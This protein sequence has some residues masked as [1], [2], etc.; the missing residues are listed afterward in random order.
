MNDRAL[1]T[2][3]GSDAR[4]SVCTPR[5]GSR[6]DAAELTCLARI[7]VGGV[8]RDLLMPD[9]D[10]ANALVDAP[11]VDVDDVSA[12]ERKDG[13]DALVLQRPGD[14]VPAG[15]DVGVTALSLQRVLRGRG[16]PVVGSV[17]RRLEHRCL[18]S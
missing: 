4:Y 5:T 14:Q 17:G 1:R 9:I 12:T 2:K 10:N 3:G 11:I 13:I 6:D 8:R 7:T 15:N 18:H 16:T